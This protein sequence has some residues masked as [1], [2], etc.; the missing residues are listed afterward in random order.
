MLY[1][2]P[3]N[4][5]LSIFIVISS[6]VKVETDKLKLLLRRIGYVNAGIRMKNADCR[7]CSVRKFDSNTDQLLK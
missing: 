4:N 2:K 7:V 6:S 3:N 5:S 1:T